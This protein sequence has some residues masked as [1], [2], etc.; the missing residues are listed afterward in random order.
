MDDPDMIA[1][2]MEVYNSDTQQAM[3]I[4]NDGSW[5][6]C[7]LIMHHKEYPFLQYEIEWYYSPG[8]RTACYRTSALEDWF[9]LPAA[10]CKVISQ[11]DFNTSDE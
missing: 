10:W 4:E 5:R 1:A 8:Q 7:S 3:D 2:F 6:G 9:P 11:A